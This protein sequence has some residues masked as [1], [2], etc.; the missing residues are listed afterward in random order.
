MLSLSHEDCWRGNVSQRHMQ[1]IECAG[2]AAVRGP[3]GPRHLLTKMR[4]GRN[5]SWQMAEWGAP[6]S[7]CAMAL[8]ATL[9][10]RAECI[11]ERL[12]NEPTQ[13]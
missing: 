1:G 9:K 2:T 3:D 4:P 11:S 7:P 8:P 5:E 12:R 13:Y 10:H 6:F